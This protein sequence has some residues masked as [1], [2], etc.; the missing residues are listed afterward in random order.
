MT[1]VLLGDGVGREH[2]A[3]IADSLAALALQAEGRGAI[4]RAAP[5]R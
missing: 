2:L 1:G 4:R 5:G 3:A